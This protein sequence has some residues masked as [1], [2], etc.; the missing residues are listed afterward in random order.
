MKHLLEN[1]AGRFD[2]VLIDLPPMA[3]LVD[4]RAISP[5]LDK[6]L[7]IVEWAVTDREVLKQALERNGPEREDQILGLVLNKIPG[8]VLKQYATYRF[9]TYLRGV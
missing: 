3:P 1:E 9:D 4:V 8:R 6:L 7:V 2:Y 5:L